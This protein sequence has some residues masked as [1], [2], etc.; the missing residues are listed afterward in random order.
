MKDQLRRDVASWREGRSMDRRARHRNQRRRCPLDRAADHRAYEAGPSPSLAEAK[1][2]STERNP[3]DMSYDGTSRRITF[4]L[5]SPAG[6]PI[7]PAI[8][9]E[10]GDVRGRHRRLA[11]VCFRHIVAIYDEQGAVKLATTAGGVHT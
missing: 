1:P 5:I 2:V 6:G 8:A 9:V 7:D 4:K 11:T 10:L 3:S